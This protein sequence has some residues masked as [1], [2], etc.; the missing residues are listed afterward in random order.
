MIRKLPAELIREI[1]AGEVINAPVDVVKELVENAL[2][3]GA[4]RLEVILQEG[5]TESITVRDNGVGIAREDLALATEAHSTSKLESL[6]AINTLGFRGEGLFAIRNAALIQLSSRPAKQLGGATLL[7]EGE[8]LSL[9][10]HPAPTGSS[11]TVSKLFHRLPARRQTLEHPATETK[12]ILTLLSRYLLHH[13]QLRLKLVID[14][15]EHWN[16]AGGNFQEAVKFFWGPVTANRLLK[17]E[18]EQ[19]AF[20]LSGLLSRP[21]LCRPR[22]DR[23]LLAVNGRPVRWPEALLKAL[24]Q[25][26]R[27]L[28]VS[29]QYPVG[30][31]NLNLAANEVLVNTA[32]DKSRIR[33]LNEAKVAAFLQE[34]VTSMLSQHPLAP[35]LPGLQTA[36]GV[37]PAPRQNFPKMRYL[38][39]FRDLYLLAEAAGQL[40]VIDQHAAHERIIYEE[41]IKRCRSEAPIELSVPEL[42][43]LSPEEAAGYL[44]RREELALIGLVLEPFGSD[45]WRLRSI[46][47]FLAGHSELLL[48]VVKGSLGRNSAEEAWRMVLGRLACLPAIKAGHKLA[49]TEAQ[50]LINTLGQCETPWACPHGRPT[51]LVLSELELARRFGRRGIRAVQNVRT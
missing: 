47:A 23:L 17:I 51:A 5:G 32:P 48:E 3:A 46:P 43:T 33:F 41:L 4:S 21:E 8:E 16:Y 6:T 40:W 19:A 29:G 45:T 28:L 12:K 7:A 14:Q 27:E 11:V 42:L 36:E 38:G 35:A 44:E 26:Y 24:L 1:A 50:T 10:E 9:L 49:N 31:L 37:A 34:A 13:P 15:T 18:S 25:A 2:D 30:V 22:R 20:R 39:T